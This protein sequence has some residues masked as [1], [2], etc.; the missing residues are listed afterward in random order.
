MKYRIALTCFGV[1]PG[2]WI[3]NAKSDES[4][5]ITG[6]VVPRHSLEKDLVLSLN[7]EKEDHFNILEHNGF[8]HKK[9]E[10]KNSKT[11][12]WKIIDLG[13]KTTLKDV[14]TT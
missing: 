11:L 1:T 6:L 14:M 4:R 8:L 13:P 3:S 7:L 12:T 9:G 10:K 5:G 2:M